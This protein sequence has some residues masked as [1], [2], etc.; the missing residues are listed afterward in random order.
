MWNVPPATQQGCA[1]LSQL[2]APPAH[3][4]P[5]DLRA[6]ELELTV[7]THIATWGYRDLLLPTSAARFDHLVGTEWAPG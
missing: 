1:R 6:I 3:D 2:A 4:L 5:D 7:A